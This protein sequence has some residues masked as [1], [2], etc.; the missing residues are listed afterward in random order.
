MGITKEMAEFLLS[1][2][3]NKHFPVNIYECNDTKFGKFVRTLNYELACPGISKDELTVTIDNDVLSVKYT[4]LEEKTDSEETDSSIIK[5][6]YI[7]GFDL[8]WKVPSKFDLQT[9]YATMANGLLTVSITAHRK[10][11]ERTIININ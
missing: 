6:Y 5:Y 2:N 9:A 4:K 8:S 7:R 10:S 11:L 3:T 1:Q